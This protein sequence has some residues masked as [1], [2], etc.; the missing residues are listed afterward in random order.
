MSPVA[1]DCASADRAPA[2]CEPDAPVV[3]ELVAVVV[4]LETG[5][6]GWVDEPQLAAPRASRPEVTSIV[7]ARM[8]PAML[9]NRPETLLNAEWR[10]RRAVAILNDM[11]LAATVLILEDEPQ[12]RDVLV[13][14]LR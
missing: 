13:R 10:T 11:M 3:D 2:P 4:A 9:G 1:A 6:P 12:L 7:I 14:S 5:V 8:P